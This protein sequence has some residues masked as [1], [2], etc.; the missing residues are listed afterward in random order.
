MAGGRVA[1][2]LD[3]ETP[4]A[5]GPA[6]GAVRY[7]GLTDEVVM[8]GCTE[9]CVKSK[10][11]KAPEFRTLLDVDQ[12]TDDDGP[13][14]AHRGVDV[15]GEPG[16]KAINLNHLL[17]DADLME[18]AQEAGIGAFVIDDKFRVAELIEVGVASL[19]TNRPARMLA[20]AQRYRS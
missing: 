6:V 10:K 19:S 3:I 20:V 16:A 5:I 7:A 14:A 2:N 12:V 11:S 17:V 1:V 18:A 8:S 13:A 15:G 9:E 4:A